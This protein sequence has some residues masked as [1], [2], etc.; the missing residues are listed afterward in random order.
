ME[1]GEKKQN[2]GIW[3]VCPKCKEGAMVPFSFKEDVFEFWKCIG[4]GYKVE[5]R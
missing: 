3:P 4:C 1:N 2:N 5:K